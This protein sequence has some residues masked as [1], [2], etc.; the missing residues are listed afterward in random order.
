METRTASDY[1]Y[2]SSDSD[3]VTV[4]LNE[5]GDPVL[6]NGKQ[7]SYSVQYLQV[8]YGDIT[9][10]ISRLQIADFIKFRKQHSVKKA[11]DLFFEI[12]KEKLS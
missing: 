2:V 1:S 6:V 11:A 10:D 5:L 9:I 3:K 12:L 7:L 4:F 8:T